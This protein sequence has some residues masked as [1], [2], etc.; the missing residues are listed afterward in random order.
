MA[1][2]TQQKKVADAIACLAVGFLVL[3][4]IDSGGGNIG[5]LIFLVWVLP[6]HL[7]VLA[8]L[9]KNKA[10]MTRMKQLPLWSY[11][12]IC[13]LVSGILGGLWCLDWFH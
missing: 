13:G 11:G 4:A 6:W 8:I 5:K 10:F 12:V 7:V 2:S 3:C 9:L 1:E